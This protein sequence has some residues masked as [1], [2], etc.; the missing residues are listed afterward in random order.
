MPLRG[1]GGGGRGLLLPQ[2]YSPTLADLEVGV[3]V[4]LEQEPLTTELTDVVLL[5]RVNLKNI[6]HYNAAGEDP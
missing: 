3:Q 1:A 6:S 5:A 4:M 2:H